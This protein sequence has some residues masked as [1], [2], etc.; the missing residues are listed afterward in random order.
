V[1]NG[2]GSQRER[3]A[4]GGKR[5]WVPWLRLVL[6][7]LVLSAVTGLALELPLLPTERVVLEEGE[8]APYDIRAP[9]SITYDST[10][11]RLE[12]QEQAAAEVEAVFTAPGPAFARQQLERAR[13]VL[14]Y[15]GSTRADDLASPEEQ[16]EWIT[17]VPELSDLPPEDV[18]RLLGL[19][20]E[21]WESV[22]W[23]TLEVTDRAMRAE[24]REDE[25]LEAREQVPALVSLDLPDEETSVTI[26]LAQ[27]LLVANSFL[28]TAATE[29]A[30]ALAREAVGPVLRTF[31]E[32]E[33][34]VREG[35]RVT[36]RD[37]EALDQLSL[38]GVQIKWQDTARAGLLALAATAAMF[39]YLARLQPEVIWD[40]QRLLLL[41]LLTAVFV[42]IGALMADEGEL[43]RYLTPVPALTI[44]AAALLGRHAGAATAI[45]IGVAIG[46][47]GDGSLE[48][49]FFAGLG[50]LAAAL[51]LGNVERIGSPFRAGAF[52]ALGQVIAVLIFWL[53]D[54]AADIG[55]LLE[56]SA[57]SLAGAG[58]SASLAL[59]GLFA[60]GPL[61]DITTT[62]RLI[63]LSR[64]DNPLLQRLLREAPATYH[65]SLLVANLAEQAAERIGADA[66]LTRVGA[67]YHDV[68]KITRPYFFVE[69]QAE[70]VNPHDRLDPRTSAEVIISHVS[71]GV[72]LARRHRLPQ[73]VRAFIPEHHG[74]AWISF[75]YDK[76][77]EQAEDP[78]LVDEDDFRYLGPKP[79]SKETALVML[80]DACEAAVA[81][82]S[83]ATAEELAEVINR[84]V[85][86]RVGDG[87]LDECDLT[88]RDLDLVR[89]SFISSL[90]GVRHPRIEYPDK[91]GQE[92]AL[93]R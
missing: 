43:L 52:A 56:R 35:A 24:I 76:A 55:A 88:L 81:A 28:D 23:E 19:T 73:R 8:V 37:L 54:G 58:I 61:F 91:N 85:A 2:V 89:E 75:L 80:A 93:S 25:L 30:Q 15:V 39:L 47:L 50:G 38:R 31:Q 60:V 7:G 59:G 14:D 68:G 36:S 40:G 57:A 49:L 90:R 3:T 65:H 11:L 44:L 18:D 12:A 70:G 32:G 86:D 62:I 13:Q 5:G 48:M 4:A 64:P 63:E 82:N 77:A 27:R 42:L 66:L 17:A 33:V 83:P 84:V 67:Y 10:V 29:E 41:V 21:G 9:R 20:Q 1:Y 16:R 79:Q 45:Y 26:L 92:Q 51:T 74:T 78:Q 22:R 34:I 71:D 6:L 87:Q 69:N 72:E 46:M 53:S